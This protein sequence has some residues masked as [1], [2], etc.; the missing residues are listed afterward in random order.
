MYVIA[1]AFRR[2]VALVG[3]IFYWALLIPLWDS[4][5]GTGGVRETALRRVRYCEEGRHVV[6]TIL[7]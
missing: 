1:C 6:L 2:V 3:K 4:L 7:L 5:S